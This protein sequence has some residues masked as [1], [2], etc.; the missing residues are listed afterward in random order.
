MCFIAILLAMFTANVMAQNGDLQSKTLDLS[1]SA[2]QLTCGTADIRVSW[3]VG[4][5][6]FNAAYLGARLSIGIP[7]G[8]DGPTAIIKVSASDGGSYFG[9]PFFVATPDGQTGTWKVDLTATTI[10]SGVILYFEADD[11][12]ILDDASGTLPIVGNLSYTAGN[13]TDDDSSN[14][15]ISH[16][17]FVLASAPPTVTAVPNCESSSTGIAGINATGTG[18]SF[19]GALSYSWTGPNGYT[20]TVEDP[21]NL[22]NAGVYTVTVEDTKRCTS[23]ASVE[24][25]GQNCAP[26][27][28]EYK[29][30]NVFKETFDAFLRWETAS[31]VNNRSFIIERSFDGRSFDKIGEVAGNGTT[32]TVEGYSFLDEGVGQPLNVETVYYRL[33]QIDFNG[34]FEYS[35]VKSVRFEKDAND[36]KLYPNPAKDMITLEASNDCEDC[37]VSIYDY[38]GKMVKQLPFISG[39]IINTADFN[40]GVYSVRLVNAASH[41]VSLKRLVIVK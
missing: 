27:P 24:L 17:T 41:T 15:D 37:L 6:D 20:S 12:D 36:V 23:T 18:N 34:D 38:Q 11:I 9:S 7:D 14:D 39:S 30:F 5:T 2:P 40:A 10:P 3:Q 22:T 35:E 32:T 16:T 31:E 21:T 8:Y 25:T 33:R 29:T 26:F 13:G 28:V 1:P 4:T 19:S